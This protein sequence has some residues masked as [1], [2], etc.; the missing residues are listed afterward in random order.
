[1][2]NHL[3]AKLLQRTLL[4]HRTE[5]CA[6]VGRLLPRELLRVV[7]PT[8]VLQD[9]YIAAM[10]SASLTGD[11][12]DQESMVR[13][14]KTIIRRH[15]INLLRK[16]RTLKMGGG[17]VDGVNDLL[18]D[19]TERLL[20]QMVVYQRTPSQSAISHEMHAIVERSLSTLQPDH[21]T[22]LRLRYTAGM[23]LADV[24]AKMS[25][26]QVAAERLCRRAMI[27]LRERLSGLIPTN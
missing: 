4:L 8:D 16:H 13:L 20:E 22:V 3:D 23:S 12:L 26:S 21:A 14:L 18:L 5:L 25:R 11:S 1:M 7:E 9:A 17:R 27:E 6:Y 2:S 19:S 10:S 15:L 24:G